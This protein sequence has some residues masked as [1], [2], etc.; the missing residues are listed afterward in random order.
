MEGMGKMELIHPE[1]QKNKGENLNAYLLS[2]ILGNPR[3][4]IQ[5]DENSLEGNRN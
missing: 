1:C 5:Q 2:Q 3:G 4:E